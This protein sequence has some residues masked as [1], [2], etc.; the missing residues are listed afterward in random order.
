MVGKWRFVYTIFDDDS[1]EMSV[2][3]EY[4]RNW[5]KFTSIPHYK[6]LTAPLFTGSLH[7]DLFVFVYSL[8]IHLMFER[9][10]S[11]PYFAKCAISTSHRRTISAIM[12]SFRAS[13]LCKPSDMSQF[14]PQNHSR[15]LSEWRPTRSECVHEMCQNWKSI[16]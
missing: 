12:Y 1:V 3:D 8:F 4:L 9:R 7:Y 13:F 2:W 15:S 5:E 10:L 16:S 11:S 14:K 6:S